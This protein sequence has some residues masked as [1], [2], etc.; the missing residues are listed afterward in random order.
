MWPTKFFQPSDQY[1]FDTTSLVMLQLSCIIN[2]VPNWKNLHLRVFH[3]E[4]NKS[5]SSSLNISESQGS[6]DESPRITNEHKLRNL[7]NM[8]RISASITKIADWNE[9]IGGINGQALPESR[10]ESAYESGIDAIECASSN[11]SKAYVMK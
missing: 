7:L 5:S 11:V 3:C 4:P 6:V 10:A 8:L 2:M 9:K 1:P